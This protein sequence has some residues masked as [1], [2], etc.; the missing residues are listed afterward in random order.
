[1]SDHEVKSAMFQLGPYKVARP[2]GLPMVFFQKHWTWVGG[3]TSRFVKEMFRIGVVPEDMNH[4]MVCLIPKQ[5]HP[6]CMAQFRPI[7]LSYIVIKVITKIIANRLKPLMKDLVG[8]NQASF[9]PGRGTKDNIV[10]AQKF[11]HSYSSKKGKKG[12]LIA[13][14]DLEKAYDMVDWNLLETLMVEIGVGKHLQRVVMS[15]ITTKNLLVLWNGRKLD[16]FKPE[17]RLRQGDI[18]SSYLFILCMESLGQA[19]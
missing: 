4:S 3:D 12:T 6:R 17:Q 2:N 11:I 14:I 16:S 13:K 8:H 15:C 9:I 1:M 19:I 10:L 7:C 5:P 18:W